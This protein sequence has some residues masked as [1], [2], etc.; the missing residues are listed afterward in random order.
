LPG[1]ERAVAK[2]A[3][4]GVMGHRSQGGRGAEREAR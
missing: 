1:L 3:S 4:A 2:A